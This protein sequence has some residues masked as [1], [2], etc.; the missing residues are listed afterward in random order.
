MRR[1][2][3]SLRSLLIGAIFVLGLL[4]SARATPTALPA[5][6]TGGV[7]LAQAMLPAANS[8][9]A[10]RWTLLRGGV[11]ALAVAMEGDVFVL[12][13]S[14]SVWRMVSADVQAGRWDRWGA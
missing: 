5:P 7:V 9:A 13:G 8:S 10:Q 11:T 1:L 3:A 2:W 14:G 6:F 4:P 12:D